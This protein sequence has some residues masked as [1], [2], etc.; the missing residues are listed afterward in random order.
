MGFWLKHTVLVTGFWIREQP[1]LRTPP[2]RKRSEVS[3]FPRFWGSS[4][5]AR[6]RAAATVGLG[7]RRCFLA[8][9]WVVVVTVTRVVVAVAVTVWETTDLVEVIARIRLVLLVTTV[10]TV[11]LVD[12]GWG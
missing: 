6:G 7:A 12:G 10:D 5:T 4:S 8:G 2:T 11:V 3:R 9:N 1:V